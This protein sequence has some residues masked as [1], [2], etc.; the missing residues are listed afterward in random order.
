MRV[1]MYCELIGAETASPK[2]RSEEKLKPLPSSA[3]WSRPAM[4][5]AEPVIG[6]ETSTLPFSIGETISK[7]RQSGNRAEAP[8]RNSGLGHAPFGASGS[9]KVVKA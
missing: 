7:A 5:A 9:G 6:A 2:D 1:A 4:K 3:A 8:V